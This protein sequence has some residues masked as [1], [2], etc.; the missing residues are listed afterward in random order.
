MHLT[1]SI[2]HPY[3]REA[4]VEPNR[5]AEDV[6]DVREVII[7]ENLGPMLATARHYLLLVDLRGRHQGGGHRH[8]DKEKLGSVLGDVS[9]ETV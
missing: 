4:E 7:S 8:H 3:E 9:V 2:A 1:M 6:E 5:D